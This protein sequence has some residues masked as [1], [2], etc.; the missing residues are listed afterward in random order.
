MASPSVAIA[1]SIK[2]REKGVMGRLLTSGTIGRVKR[3][4]RG[5]VTKDENASFV[6]M[7]IIL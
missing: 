3:L 2:R 4:W 6:R 7:P 5:F 1:V